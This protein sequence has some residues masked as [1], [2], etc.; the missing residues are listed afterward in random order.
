MN[1]DENPSEREIEIRQYLLG[2]LAPDAHAAVEARIAEDSEYASDVKA[3]R[4]M[5][6]LAQAAR[7]QSE[8]DEEFGQVDEEVRAQVRASAERVRQQGRP[9]WRRTFYFS[10]A[11]AV[12]LL[13][14]VGAYLW[15]R[16]PLGKR[17]YAEH[18]TRAEAYTITQGSAA[19]DGMLQYRDKAYEKAIA[20][21]GQ[22]PANDSTYVSARFYLAQAHM[23]LGQTTAAVAVL[24]A[25]VKLP[26]DEVLL[27]ETEW[28]LA[29]GYLDV[30]RLEDAKDYLQLLSDLP[31]GSARKAS[32]AEILEALR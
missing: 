17:L 15:V 23:A 6:A 19:Q 21:L 31:P 29:L 16:P 20:T 28:Y 9:N 25:L 12:A 26:M 5:L 30:G 3:M 7:L 10:A 14:A 2:Q 13:A 22:V 1:F 24:E 4:W 27:H 11:A 8:R 18:Y 32:A